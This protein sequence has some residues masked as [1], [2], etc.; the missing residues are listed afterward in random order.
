LN[1][2]LSNTGAARVSAPTVLD[3]ANAALQTTTQI[4]FN[5]PPTT[6]QVDGAGPLIPYTSGG[7]IDVNGWRV[8][9]TGA[10]VAGDSF[11]VQANTNG[12][13]DNANGLALFG[14]RSTKILDGNTATYQDAFGQLLGKV[15]AQTQQAQISRDALRV[16]LDNAEAARDAVAGVNLDEEAA[17]L[18]RYQQSYQGAAQV[19][20]SA[21]QMF[22]ALIQAIR[23]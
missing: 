12:R 15:A 18:V 4:V 19:I 20:A 2:S 13:G 5:N 17:N 23:G 8:Q 6:Y 11:S 9:I 3:A 1:A 14:L 22:Q 7:N 10:P 21:E 16:Q